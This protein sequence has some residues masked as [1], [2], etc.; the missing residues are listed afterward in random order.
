MRMSPGA[1]RMRA[2]SFA[3]VSPV[4][5]STIG[6]RQRQPGARL[7]G[8]C[9]QGHAQV[10][11]D[12]EGQ[13]LERRDVEHACA[14]AAR[15]GGGARASSRSMATRNAASVLPDPVGASRRVDSPRA[16]A[17][18]PSAW[19]RVGSPSAARNQAGDGRGEE[20]ERR[21]GHWDGPSVCVARKRARRWRSA[22]GGGGSAPGGGGARQEVAEAR[23][24]VAEARQEVAEARQE[25]AERAR[26][27]RKRLRGSREVY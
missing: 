2:R 5:T 15:R 6:R 22:P 10:A 11:F 25:V 8:D 12:V 3:D 21:S 13:R 16:M 9:R 7:L 4:R 17:G 27:W 1:R 19:A 18:Q 24:E 26:R 23:Q 14:P 20:V